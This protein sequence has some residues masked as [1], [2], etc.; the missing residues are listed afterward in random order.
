M[1]TPVAT[2]AESALDDELA[3]PDSKEDANR[4]N[5]ITYD[6]VDE[7]FYNEAG[8]VT[9][10]N[11]EHLDKSVQGPEDEYLEQTRNNNQPSLSAPSA[12]SDHLEAVTLDLGK[13]TADEP[14]PCFY[15][16]DH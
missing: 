2:P 16:A 1:I 3:A 12:V 13:H 15:N 6:N 5:L 11:K 9:N 8:L 14:L 7:R 4:T 10:V